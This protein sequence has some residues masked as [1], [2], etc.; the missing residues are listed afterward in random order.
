MSHLTLKSVVIGRQGQVAWELQRCLNTLGPVTAVGRP[1]IDLSRPDSIRD[2]IRNLEPD[3]VVNAAGYTAVD[4]AETEPD[5]AIKINAEAPR[6][7]AE[8]AQQR[9]ALFVTYSSDYVFDGTKSSP[10]TESDPAS[11]LGIYGASKLAGDRSVQ[12]VAGA[13]LIFRTSWVYGTRGKNFLSTIRRHAGDRAELKVVDDQVGAPTW[14]R[15][16]AYA[17][18]SVLH[19]LTSGVSAKG[20]FRAAEVL[21]DRSGIYN[22]TSRGSTSW[23]GFATAILEEMN[24]HRQSDRPLSRIIPISSQEYPAAAVRPK[25][26]R[27]SNEKLRHTFG[28]ELPDWRSSLGKVMNEIEAYEK[29]EISPKDGRL[30]QGSC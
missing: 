1:E 12:A 23:Y 8:E 22:M 5:L 15:D 20:S 7:M 6:V 16:I 18:L 24:L 3:V 25:N 17:T 28:V 14:S 19:Q 30:V 29:G 9:N 10:Y 4:Q 2:T 11:P 13:Y 27:L 26:S 21:A